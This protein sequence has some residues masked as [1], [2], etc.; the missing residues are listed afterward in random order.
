MKLKWLYFYGCC[1]DPRSRNWW[2]K[3]GQK[4]GIFGSFPETVRRRECLYIWQW[5]LFWIKKLCVF[6]ISLR[7][8]KKSVLK[9]VDRA[10]YDHS[11]PDYVAL[12]PGV[13]ALQT[14]GI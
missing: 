6:L 11:T 9:L 4:R 3:E 14:S 1:W 7:F 5:S 12:R 8:K 13:L 10:V 2:I